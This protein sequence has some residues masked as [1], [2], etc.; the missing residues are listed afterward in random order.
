[1]LSGQ[2]S[3]G[4]LPTPGPARR[5][6]PNPDTV[7]Y[8]DMDQPWQRYQPGRHPRILDC[9][10][11]FSSLGGTHV[12]H[13]AT[14]Q[15]FGSESALAV[16]AHMRLPK[17]VKARPRMQ[18]LLW[19]SASQCWALQRPMVAATRAPPPS[20]TE[21][22]DYS[23]VVGSAMQL[24]LQFGWMSGQPF[25]VLGYVV[26]GVLI[27]RNRGVCAWNPH[28][29]HTAPAAAAGAACV[30]LRGV[31]PIGALQV[32][33]CRCG[34]P[35]VVRKGQWRLLPLEGGRLTRRYLACAR[36]SV[37]LRCAFRQY[38]D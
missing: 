32:V 36:K 11:V 34:N 18:G 22:N 4:A 8:G 23:N 14:Q 15:L 21:P 38:L 28:C 31:T 12:L 30:L 19:F 29:A 7:K 13:S 37:K 1:M 17:A 2:L 33:K 3:I 6:V 5:R 27:G 25:A 20:G 24:V 10:A 26:K 9:Q 35:A 16:T